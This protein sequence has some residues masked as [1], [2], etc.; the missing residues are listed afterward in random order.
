MI[1]FLTPTFGIE[2]GNNYISGQVEIYHKEEWGTIC[3]QDFD[4]NDANVICK[5]AGYKSGVY[6][7]YNKGLYKQNGIWGKKIW[8]SNLKCKGTEK[9]VDKCP[10][11]IW[12]KIDRR[13]RSTDNV[14]IT[15][16]F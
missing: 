3:S 13:C 7:V 5:T 4:D 10:G 14:E 16:Y 1:R 11:I 8:L 9:V 12:G 6:G 15:C 2:D